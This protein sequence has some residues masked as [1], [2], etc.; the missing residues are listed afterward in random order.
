MSPA[1]THHVLSNADSGEVEVGIFESDHRVT[2]AGRH[3]QFE[4]LQL[5]Q[6]EL[7]ARYVTCKY[8]VM[9]I[10]IIYLTSP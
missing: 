8:H 2:V 1:L 10:I 9:I 6:T 3:Q 4:E 7:G 5:R